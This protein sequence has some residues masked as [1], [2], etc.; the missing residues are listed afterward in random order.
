MHLLVALVRAYSSVVFIFGVICL[1]NDGKALLCIL[2]FVGARL[3]ATTI[4]SVLS[5]NIWAGVSLVSVISSI[6]DLSH[7]VCAA[8]LLRAIYST[9]RLFETT[10]RIR[11]D[12]QYISA[13]A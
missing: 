1:G 6:S 8:V 4:A 5:M 11:L 13:P 3:L 2:I 12:H 10:K 9:S 7:D